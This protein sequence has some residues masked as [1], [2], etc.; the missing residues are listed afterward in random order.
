[1]RRA[2]TGR[3]WLGREVDVGSRLPGLGRRGARWETALR[4]DQ[5]DAGGTLDQVR[6][7]GPDRLRHARGREH[8]GPRRRHVRR[9]AAD[10][11][12]GAACGRRGADPVHAVQDDLPVEQLSRAG[13]AVEGRRA[14]RAAV[15]P[16]VAERV[17]GARR[18][19][20][21]AAVL[22]R[23]R[24]L[25]GRARHR[26]RPALQQR[27]RGRSRRLHLRLHL[28]RRRHRRRHHQQGPDLRA[29]GARQELR[30]LRRVRPGD[31]DRPRPVAAQRSDRG[32]RQRAPELPGQR[33]DL[34]AAPAGELSVPGHDAPARRRDRL[35]HLGRGRRH[36]QPQQPDRGLD[37]R[38]R[39]AR[40]HLRPAGA[41]QVFR[42]PDQ[43]DADL[44]GRRR[45][46][47]RPDGGEARTRRPSRDRDRHGR[48]SRRDPRGRPEADLGGR[49]RAGRRGQGGRERRRGRAA[50]SRDPGGQGALPRSGGARDRRHA[51]APDHDHDGPERPALVVFPKARRPVRRPQA[52]NPRSLGH[53]RA[54]DR[55]GPG[56][57]AA[58]STRP[59]TS[60]HP[61]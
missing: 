41:V 8:H 37:R 59:R 31:R 2:G 26:H 21:A 13:R 60:A 15:L 58:S 5:G 9:P 47:R 33:H 27:H 30:H 11:G 56:A 35:R 32:G 20:P 52:G 42:G 1:M 50:G 22:R 34:P 7:A 51:R 10:R 40:Q 57:R 23:Q 14:G 17:P 55:S 25:R 39:H 29:V 28:R 38:H 54:Q 4:N 48:A 45:R 49:Q 16:E 24:R 6:A 19:D 36:A 12:D 44:R 53:P 43:A 46:D 3:R 61:A 18:D